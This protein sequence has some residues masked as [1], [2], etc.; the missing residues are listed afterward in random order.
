[1]LVS[2]YFAAHGFKSITTQ[3]L[4]NEEIAE[5]EQKHAEIKAAKEDLEL[6]VGLLSS[7]HVD[8]DFLD[9]L[10]RKELGFTHP[11]EIVIPDK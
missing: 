9:E 4:L 8:P 1:M 3:K 2:V 5:L 6:H 7:D 10:A 11:D